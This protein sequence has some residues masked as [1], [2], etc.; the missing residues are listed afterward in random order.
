ML[1]EKD[2]CHA[3]R[4]TQITDGSHHRS[5]RPVHS[6]DRT[7]R[8]DGAA[9]GRQTARPPAVTPGKPAAQT[10]A[11][12]AKPAAAPSIVDGGWPRIYDLPS[13]GRC[14][15][16]SR[17]SR[18]GTSR[19]TS[20]PSAPSRY[21][22]KAGDKPALG[23]IKIEADTK[24]AARR[25]AGQLSEDE[26][27]RGELPDAAEGAGARDH[28]RDR[29]GDSRRRAR[30]SRSIACSRIS[31]RARSCRRTSRASRPI[32]RRSSSARRRP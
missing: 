25:T 13:G 7:D 15:S 2:F 30:A 12:S 32:R 14:S 3:P 5:V 27:R 21:R 19:R 22:A 29:Q 24:V 16:T 10:G 9:V 8:P 6:G 11:A 28:R 26:D 23:T 18:A 1:Q 17:R 31:T 20:S 4:D